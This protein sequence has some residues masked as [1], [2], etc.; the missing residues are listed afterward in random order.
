MIRTFALALTLGL[1]A[2]SSAL[3]NDT[4][5]HLTTGGLEYTRSDVVAMEE[6]RLYISPREVKV[7]YVFRNTG[8]RDVRTYVA[9]PM[10]DIASGVMWDVDAGN[11]EDDNFLGFTVEQD[12]N[13]ITPALQ[14]RIY[15]GALDMTD[16]FMRAGIPANPL[17]QKAREALKNLPDDVR[18]DWIA[19]GIIGRDEMDTGDGKVVEYVPLWTLKSAYYWMTTFPAGKDVRVSH[20][21]RPSVGGTV[22]VTYLD[23]NNQPRGERYEE[24]VRKYCIDDAFV[25]IARKSIED[26]NS[27]NSHLVENWIS[28]VLT[29][30]A[31]WSGP[32]KRF[33][34]VVD[35]G[36][37]DNYVSFCGTGVRKTGPTTFE[38][39]ATDY[40]PERNLDI[41]LLVPTGAP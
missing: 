9:F 14:Q 34:L 16:T 24:Y 41:L 33:T 19:R 32:I 15:V 21:Y 25:R 22:A 12:G 27:G 1:L 35:K 3:A 40:F 30:G 4:M 36:E 10:P 11:T 39:T 6:E 31:N 17:S 2:S 7:D 13:R 5:A 28:Y 8:D 20:R 18:E 37:V 23:E 38:M 26:M 29:T